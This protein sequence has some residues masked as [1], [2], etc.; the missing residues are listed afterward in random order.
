[1]QGLLSKILAAAVDPIRDKEIIRRR[2]GRKRLRVR[3]KEQAT[4]FDRRWEGDAN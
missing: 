2:G 3:A 1:M 4:G